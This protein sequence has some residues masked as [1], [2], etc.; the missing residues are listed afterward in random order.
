MFYWTTSMVYQL[1]LPPTTVLD[2]GANIGLFS[3]WARRC[4]PAATIHA[5]E[6]N[7][8]ITAFTKNNLAQ[9]SIAFFAEGIGSQSGFAS[10]IDQSESRLSQFTVGAMAGIKV[11]SLQEA[12]DRLGGNVD[13]LKLDCEGAEWEIFHDP[14]PFANIESVRM[15]YHLTDGKTIADVKQVVESLGYA[16]DHLEENIGFGIIWF[17]RP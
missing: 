16:V 8:R 15:E 7:P 10:G 17:S 5:Y 12:V 6:P 14:T 1:F 9:G 11:I 4:F 13:L 3:L 2:I